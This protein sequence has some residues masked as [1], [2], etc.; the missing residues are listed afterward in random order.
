LAG[1]LVSEITYNVVEWDVKHY[2]IY[3]VYLDFGFQ[4]VE[5]DALNAQL[6]CLSTRHLKQLTVFDSTT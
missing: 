3:K 2:Y 4:D 6:V 1:K 5:A